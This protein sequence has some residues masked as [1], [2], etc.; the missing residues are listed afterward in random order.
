MPQSICTYGFIP[1]RTEPS[2]AS[3]MET[4]ILFGET[5][6]IME[7][8]NN[9]ALVKLRYD[10][11]TGWID[12]KLID[13]LDDR[14]V[15]LWERSE[16]L[17]IKGSFVK[18][19]KESDSTVQYLTAGSRVVFNGN[20]RNAIRIGKKEFYWQGVADKEKVDIE[21][22]ARGFLNTP[23]LWGG[24]S[25]F[26]IDCSG[27]VQ[28][29]YKT[30]GIFMPRNASQQIEKGQ[31]VSYVEEAQSGDLAFFDDEEGNIVHVGI[32]LGSGRIIHASG[33]VRID[34]LDHQGIF[35]ADLRKYTHRLRVI[36]RVL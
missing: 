28:V 12:E 31:V 14:D 33:S 9:W 21:E 1:V 6:E 8:H 36:K 32:C 15:E 13:N 23:Y 22:V 2:E 27:L 4:Q 34:T 20:E 30:A 17:I 7:R 29:V 5:Y 19:V 24:R 11:Y 25:F 3:Q 10:G 18:V 26:G 35:N 16:G